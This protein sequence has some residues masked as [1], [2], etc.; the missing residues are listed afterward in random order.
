ML[1]KSKIL[2]SSINT[3]LKSQDSPFKYYETLIEPAVEIVIEKGRV[4]ASMLCLRFNIS[5]EEAKALIEAMQKLG[6]IAKPDGMG[7]CAALNQ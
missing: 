1:I 4:S 7:F 3:M 6:V 2:N 5:D